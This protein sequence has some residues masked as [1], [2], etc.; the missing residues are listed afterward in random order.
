MICYY[1]LN[2]KVKVISCTTIQHL[3]TYEPRDP[4]FQERIHDYHGSLESTLG[5]EDFGNSSYGYEY[6]INYYEEGNA[7]GEPNQEE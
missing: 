7:K 4:N 6:F 3:N 1:I 2:E 5:S